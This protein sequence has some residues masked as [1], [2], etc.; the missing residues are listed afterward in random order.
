MNMNEFLYALRCLWSTL[1]DDVGWMTDAQWSDFESNP[2]KFF[3]H[4]DDETAARLWAMIRASQPG[5]AI[6]TGKHTP[7]KEAL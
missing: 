4:A 5:S 2:H 6:F 1:R 7:D 3:M